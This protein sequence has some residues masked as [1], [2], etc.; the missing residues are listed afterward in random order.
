MA[1][2]TLASYRFCAAS[3]LAAARSSAQKTIGIM[4]TGGGDHEAIRK[5]PIERPE[6]GMKMQGKAAL[7]A[8]AL[9]LEH[10]VSLP[11]RVTLGE[12]QPAGV[13]KDQGERDR[14]VIHRDM[15]AAHDV[16]EERMADI[17]PG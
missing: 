14:L 2:R 3:A 1:S 7:L 17:G 11:R 10:A 15:M 12:R 4:L 16:H 5:I 13:R 6:L 8:P 9:Q